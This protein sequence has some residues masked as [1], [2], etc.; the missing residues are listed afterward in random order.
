[1]ATATPTLELGQILA[2]ITPAL[3]RVEQR[4][5]EQTAQFAPELRDYLQ[6]ALDGQ[7]KRLRPALALL[8]AATVRGSAE[9]PGAT[10]IDLGVIV[11][12]IHMATLVHDDVMDEAQLRHG[13]LT[14]AARWNNETAVL[15]G[16]CLFAHALKLAASFPTTEVCR[17]VSEATNTVCS[18]EILQTSRRFDPT[19]TIA[20]YLR[21]IE[22]K[23]GALFAVSCD[24][25]AYLTHADLRTRSALRQF[26]LQ[27][28]AAYQIYD[29]CVDIFG[30]E[31]RAGKSLGTDMAR[32]KL[33]LPM[34]ICLQQSDTRERKA[35]WEEWSRGAA[36]L[37]QHT[38]EEQRALDRSVEM[39][40]SYLRSAQESLEQLPPPA[41]TSF[42]ERTIQFLEQQAVALLAARIAN[43][44][45]PAAVAAG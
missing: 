21:I 42:L 9:P 24:L 36:R 43:R 6:H 41:A 32:G 28:G 12:L 20:D 26:G 13:Q 30:D 15:L 14:V 45:L 29:D 19:L 10:L 2:P 11:E 3:Q 40:G 31:E 22:M 35:L 38:L 1:M 37:L 4:L 18:G 8:S 7:G 25:G 5:S 44:E 27:L 33:T 39:L 34:L 17:C 23:T 16:D